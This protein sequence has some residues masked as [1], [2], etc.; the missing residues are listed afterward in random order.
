MQF[1]AVSSKS[2]HNML[3]LSNWGLFVLIAQVDPLAWGGGGGGRGGRNPDQQLEVSI[4]ETQQKKSQ[5]FDG[6]KV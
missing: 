5:L 1:L 3:Y 6:S 2:S 4:L